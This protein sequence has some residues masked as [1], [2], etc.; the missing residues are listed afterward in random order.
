MQ[1]PVRPA[2]AQAGGVPMA[3][4]MPFPIIQNINQLSELSGI[5]VAT[6]TSNPAMQVA[7]QQL[8]AQRLMQQQL[9]AQGG[10]MRP[11]AMLPAQM[12]ALQQAQQAQM[13]Q[14]LAA[15]TGATPATGK[16]TG[17]RRRGRPS[18]AAAAAAASAPAV[19]AFAAAPAMP[20]NPFA[21]P[22]G[23]VVWAKVGSYPWWP[24]KTLD[25]QRDLSYPPDA[26]PP[27]PTSIPI[28]FFGTF[29]FQWI[30]SKRQ[31]VDWEEGFEQFSRECDQSSF[32][33][34]IEEVQHYKATGKLPDVFYTTPEP[35]K[36]KP[37]ARGKKR[38]ARAATDAAEFMAAAVAGSQAAATVKPRTAGRVAEQQ[39]DRAELVKRRRK[40]RLKEL[41]L[42]PPD[43][44]PY[45]DGHV[46]P[47]PHLLQFEE[48]WRS[49]YAHV[50]EEQRQAEAE[51]A[52][53]RA[54]RKAA[55]DA[56]A[57]E[58]A[59][60][61]EAARQTTA[62]SAA[63]AQPVLGMQ[64]QVAAGGQAGMLPLGSCSR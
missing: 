41:G 7:A 47:N 33:A 54:E 59:A 15:A 21:D 35:E 61:E 64:Q 22:G 50:I 46:A 20:G 56:A 1:Q 4:P 52:Q 11:A 34:A 53:R 30:G 55:A 24:A 38:G 37:K 25:P 27:R 40:Q 44:S 42:L 43:N 9:R 5:P 45:I 18:A 13:Q 17:G 12:L 14:R 31:L 32:K 8:V 29:E 57:R 60:A 48:Q 2:G 10:Q 28:R 6:L 26:D 3:V 19:Q 51:L 49:Q 63:A 23:R 58:R 39:E 62:A 16:K 36:P